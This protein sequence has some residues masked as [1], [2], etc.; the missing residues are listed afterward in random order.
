M[1]ER[2]AVKDERLAE[3][4]RR[5]LEYN[6]AQVALAD[7]REKVKRESANVRS[8]FINLLRPLPGDSK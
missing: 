3:A 8:A 1:N 5:R 7:A 2:A 6:R 4:V